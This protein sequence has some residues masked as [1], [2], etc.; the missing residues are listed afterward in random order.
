MSKRGQLPELL[1]VKPIGGGRVKVQHRQ[2]LFI[3]E[4]W[5]EDGLPKRCRLFSDESVAVNVEEFTNA[6]GEFMTAYIQTQM[7][8]PHPEKANKKMT[9]DR[10]FAKE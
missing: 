5:D 9:G 8:D 10:D 7:L 1:F 3:V 6:G 2:V 4:E